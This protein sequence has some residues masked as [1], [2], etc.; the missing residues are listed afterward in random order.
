MFCWME[1][2]LFGGISRHPGL[3]EMEGSPMSVQQAF[4]E[5]IGKEDLTLEKYQVCI[6]FLI[7]RG[8]SYEINLSGLLLFKTT[9]LCCYEDKTA[10]G[11]VSHATSISPFLYNRSEQRFGIRTDTIHAQ[12][13]FL[14]RSAVICTQVRLVETPSNKPMVRYQHGLSYVHFQRCFN[15]HALILDIG[16]IF[17]SMRFIRN[18]HDVPLKVRRKPSSPYD[19]FFNLY[20]PSTP[21]KKTSPP[22]P[23]FTVTVVK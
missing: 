11:R 19:F 23:D 18:G 5:M 14:A 3:E 16:S 12:E 15:P 2:D 1:H 8:T 6:E 10:N 7:P 21:Y 17:R 22:I 20:K 4:T 9:W 13:L